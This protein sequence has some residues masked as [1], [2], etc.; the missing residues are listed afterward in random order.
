[1]AD[2]I[3]DLGS[4]FWN[5]RGTLRVAAIVNVGTQCS[6]VRLAKDRFIFLDSYTLSGDVR[7]KIMALTDQGRQVAAV[8]N[9][10]PFHTLHV[11]QM[12]EDF[13][14]AAFY[15]S[16]R[17]KRKL[18]DIDWQDALVE[19]DEVAA[20]FPELAFSLPSG[21][22]YLSDNES[23]HAGSLLVYHPASRSL[24]VDDTFMVSPL[25]GILEWMLRVPRIAFHPTL[26]KALQDRPDAGRDFCDWVE[27]IAEDWGQTRNLC[28]AHSD[29]RRFDAGDFSKA[30]RDQL[31]KIRP[32]LMA[33]TS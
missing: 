2:K 21:I 25:P 33:A 9:V 16:A 3:I 28:A 18:P 32:T 29:I 24:H 14:Q 4:G 11:A 19:S 5:V 26:K 1:M 31:S 30:L 10:H 17:H 8:L 15:G 12:A 6:L 22:D 20:L 13:P 7:D 23:V 27:N